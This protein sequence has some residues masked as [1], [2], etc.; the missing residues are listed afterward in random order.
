MFG[1][2]VVE[3]Q[4]CVA[5]F[6]EAFCGLRILSLVGIDE[7]VE[8]LARM[9]AS[10]VEPRNQF[11]YALDFSQVEWP[12]LRGELFPLAFWETIVN[13]RLLDFE[14]AQADRNLAL[15]VVTVADH[16]AMAHVVSQM[17]VAVD[18]LGSASMTVANTRWA[19]AR[20]VSVSTS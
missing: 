14:L 8:R 9:L 13:T 2:E 20:R 19:P 5:I 1:G 10:E 15:A 17:S 16:L 6:T 7:Q 4:Q 12:N 3:S 18:P 11:L